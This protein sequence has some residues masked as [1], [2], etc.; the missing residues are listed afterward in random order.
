MAVNSVSSSTSANAQSVRSQK[1]PEQAQQAVQAT[2]GQ[3]KAQTKT[4]APRPPQPVV[5]TQ[6]Q[7]IGT[8]VNTT[9]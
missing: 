5:N 8:R 7:K 3:A 2:Q 1:Q 6:G 9:A 4:E